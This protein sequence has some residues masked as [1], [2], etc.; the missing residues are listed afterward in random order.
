MDH[1]LKKVSNTQDC[2]YPGDHAQGKVPVVSDES[3]FVEPQED[4]RGNTWKA[5]VAYARQIAHVKQKCLVHLGQVRLKLSLRNI[6]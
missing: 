1:E 5:D 6:S 3:P 4:M 2:S